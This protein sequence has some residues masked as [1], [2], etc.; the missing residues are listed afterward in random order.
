MRVRAKARL[1]VK[2]GVKVMDDG[3]EGEMEMKV[4][5]RVPQQ[6]VLVDADL[7]GEVLGI[8]VQRV[9]AQEG[10]VIP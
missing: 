10:R 5:V 2:V 4:K 8:I 9:D 3:C 1:R 6:F 7:F